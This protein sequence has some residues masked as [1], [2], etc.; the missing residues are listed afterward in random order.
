MRDGVGKGDDDDRCCGE[1]GRVGDDGSEKKPRRYRE[2]M[3]CEGQGDRWMQ[4]NSASSE[5][6]RR[7]LKCRQSAHRRAAKERTKPTHTL[8]LPMGP[9]DRHKARV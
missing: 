9:R 8:R 1:G 4:C 2:T 6:K 7:W 5:G 3:E